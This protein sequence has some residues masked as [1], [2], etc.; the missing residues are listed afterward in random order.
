LLGAEN[1]SAGVTA[2]ANEVLESELR[3]RLGQ[4]RSGNLPR[5]T[6]RE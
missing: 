5:G 1:T 4:A 2:K 3:A 6:C